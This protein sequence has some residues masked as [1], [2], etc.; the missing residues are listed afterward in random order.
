[1]TD[2]PDDR[3]LDALDHVDRNGSLAWVDAPTPEV[4]RLYGELQGKG[5]IARNPWSDRFEVTDAGK[6]ARARSREIGELLGV[7][8]RQNP[9]RWL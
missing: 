2:I 3:V 4:T 7:P 1:M 6:A 9:E 5:Y 8:A